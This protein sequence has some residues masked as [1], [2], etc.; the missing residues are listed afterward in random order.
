MPNW[1]S[2]RFTASI[3]GFQREAERSEAMS[4]VDAVAI[5]LARAS[6][7]DNDGV[8][9]EDDQPKWI[10]VGAPLRRHR[11]R[12]DRVRLAGLARPGAERQSYG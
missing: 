6:S 9:E 4:R 5:Q 11:K 12:P 10:L 8:G 1:L 7:R 3:A 2:V